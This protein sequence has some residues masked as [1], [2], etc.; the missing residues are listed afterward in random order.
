MDYSFDVVVAYSV[1]T[2]Y[3]TVHYCT[4]SELCACVHSCSVRVCVHVCM[5]DNCICTRAIHSFCCS[6]FMK[7][8]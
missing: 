7:C 2:S 1:N 4:C 5:Y 8:S 6:Q 3:V